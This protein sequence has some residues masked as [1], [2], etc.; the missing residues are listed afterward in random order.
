MEYTA[1]DVKKLREQTNATFADCKNALAEAKDWG[2]AVKILEARSDRKAEKMIAAGRETKQGGVFSYVHHNHNVGVLL[3][4]NCSTDFVA[5][6]ESFRELA[7]E[8]ALQIAG[9][10]PKYINFEDVPADVVEAERR[11]ILEDEAIARVPEA[12]REDFING[13]LKKVFGEQVL[14][15]QPYVKDEAV[16]VSDLVRKVIA[17]TGENIVVRRFSRFA[18]GEE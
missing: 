9:V 17:E 15:M 7:R 6:S 8:L 18:L 2:Q 16:T 10:A 11:K 14:M 13:K 4:L 5:R 1:A 12:R 3:E